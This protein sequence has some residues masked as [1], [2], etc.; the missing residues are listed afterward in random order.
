[1]PADQREHYYT[2]QPVSVRHPVSYQDTLRGIA[3]TFWTDHGVFSRGHTD[4]GTAELL[5]AMEVA[6]AQ[7]ILDLGCGYG[8]VGIVAARLA[9]SARVILTDPNERAVELA[10]KNLTDNGILNAEARV[11]EGYVPVAG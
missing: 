11:G 3:F 6:G 9:A 2:P 7:A 10:Q 1:M 4:T 8:I 5:A